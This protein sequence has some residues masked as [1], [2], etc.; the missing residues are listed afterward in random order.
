[1]GN[2]SGD[3]SLRDRGLLGVL[4]SR[5]AA[6]PVGR[7]YL[8]DVLR[9]TAAFVVLIG[10]YGHFFFPAASGPQDLVFE[11]L[12][13]FWLLRPFYFDGGLA[14]QLFFVLS[15]FVFFS[16]YLAAIQEGRVGA[17]RFFVLRFSRLYPLHFVTLIIVAGLQILAVSMNGVPIVYP[18]N[19][20]Y[21]FVLNLLFISH[22]GLQSGWSFNAPVW[23]VSVEL[24]LYIGFFILAIT[25]RTTFAARMIATVPIAWIGYYLAYHASNTLQ[26]VG[27]GIMCFYLGGLVFLLLDRALSA[28]LRPAHIVAAVTPILLITTYWIADGRTPR[29]AHWSLVFCAALFPSLV[30]LLAALQHVRT[31]IGRSV[32]VWG[33]ISYASYLI[34]FPIQAV[35]I[36]LMR[37]GAIKPDLYSQLFLLLYVVLVQV[38]AVATYYYFELPAQ[39]LLRTRLLGRRT[40]THEVARELDRAVVGTDERVR[41]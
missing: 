37:A 6:E 33:D 25:I 29:D 26:Q 22:W 18:Y 21:H 5:R 36:L 40:Q 23:S 30:L 17:W 16:Q 2:F 32:R 38:S 39:K 1:M 4:Q 14:V 28:G 13:F 35:L 12:P 27:S 20:A 7:Y 24:L 41:A 10:H 19:D 11:K 31:N 3:K 9:G 34:H 8:L 15:G